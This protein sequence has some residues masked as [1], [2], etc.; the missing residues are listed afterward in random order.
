M[1]IKIYFGDKPLFLCDDITPDLEPFLHHD[2]AV[3]IDEFSTPAL[4][5]MIYEMEL[6][7]IHAGILKH[8]DLQALKKAFWKKFTIIQAGGGA[9]WNEKHA[10]LF[11]HRR[12]KWDLPK[13]KLD[14]G[15]TIEHCAVREVEE[16]TGL[17]GASITRPLLTTY[18][19]YHESGKH[20]LKETVWFEMKIKG[21]QHLKPQT[22]EDIHAAEWLAKKD[23]G[24]VNGNTF[25]SIRDV[26]IALGERRS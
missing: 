12:G 24:K 25:P 2:D 26:I 14:E 8:N 4:K 11:I 13:G 10:L 23:W 20:I 18:H 3:F 9:V 7:G 16:E 21:D 1:Y 15:E 6:P 17:Q 19:T 5:S 22:E